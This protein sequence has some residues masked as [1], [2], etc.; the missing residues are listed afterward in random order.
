MKNKTEKRIDC[1]RAAIQLKS[2]LDNYF[3]VNSV[4]IQHRFYMKDDEYRFTMEALIFYKLDGKKE[5]NFHVTVYD[6]DSK[7]SFAELEEKAIEKAH[8]LIDKDEIILTT[9]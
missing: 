7:L 4:E 3:N 9:Y 8:S 5:T 6:F 2:K 1:F